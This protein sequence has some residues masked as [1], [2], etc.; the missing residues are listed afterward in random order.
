MKKPSLNELFGA[1]DD[2]SDETGTTVVENTPPE[3]LPEEDDTLG[4]ELDDLVAGTP[5]EEEEVDGEEPPPVVVKPPPKKAPKKAPPPAPPPAEE[6]VDEEAE[7]AAKLEAAKR[8]KAERIAAAKKALEEAEEGGEDVEDPS[9]GETAIS[10]IPEPSLPAESGPVTGLV[11]ASWG[12]KIAKYPIEK[13]KGVS[14]VKSRIS[15][16][17][18]EHQG[19]SFLFISKR[20]YSEE[21]GGF[22]CFGGEC[23]EHMGLPDVRY[24]FPVVVYETDKKGN[25]IGA[26]FEIQYLQCPETRYEEFLTYIENGQDLTNMDFVV[27]CED[28]VYQKL[29]LA[30]FMG[31]TWRKN[32]AFALQIIQKVIKLWAFAPQVIASKMTPERLLEK[33]S[34]VGGGGEAPP[35]EDFNLDKFLKG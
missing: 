19:E 26:D 32:K 10:L 31:A 4:T 16:P 20:H 9:Q 22:Y 3:D 7:L 33:L 21:T 11:K 13:F 1:M 34:I 18:L 23:C 14:G 29:K 35:E 5:E 15:I 17:L 12:T 24:N 30:G 8:A 28:E 25:V 6:E 2:D 27:T